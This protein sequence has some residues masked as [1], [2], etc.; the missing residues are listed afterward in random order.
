MNVH[1]KAGFPHRIKTAEGGFRMR[2]TLAILIAVFG[3]SSA[4]VFG[5]TVPNPQVISSTS[6]V[7][8]GGVIEIDGQGFGNLCQ[9]SIYTVDYDDTHGIS[10]GMLGQNY[11]QVQTVSDEV[12]RYTLPDFLIHY[13]QSLGGTFATSLNPGVYLLQVYVENTNTYAGHIFVTVLPRGETPLKALASSD[14]P[15]I[16]EGYGTTFRV[17]ASGG[18]GSYSYSWGGDLGGSKGDGTQDTLSASTSPG[19]GLKTI[20]CTVTS[21]SQVF[22][23]STKVQ[24]LPFG[25][26]EI[27]PTLTV[28]EFGNS[29]GPVVDLTP[30]SLFSAQGLQLSAKKPIYRKDLKQQ[31]TTGFFWF[32]I[33]KT[34]YPK[35]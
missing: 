33:K 12:I 30:N 3:F 32:L 23:A 17:L 27:R 16:I 11:Q 25:S 28:S 4:P 6:V 14:D 21:G 35:G 24:V 2:C 9:I 13:D 20:T 22:V 1:G 29:Q 10:Y 31:T 34:Y 26:E 19:T 8:Q 18:T 7:E 5:Q 15:A